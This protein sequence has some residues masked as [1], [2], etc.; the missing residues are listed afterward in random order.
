VRLCRLIDFSVQLFREIL[1][2]FAP[3]IEYSASLHEAPGLAI[4]VVFQSA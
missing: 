4:P 2:G 1:G 3:K